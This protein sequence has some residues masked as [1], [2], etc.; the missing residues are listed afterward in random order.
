MRRLGLLACL[1]LLLAACSSLPSPSPASA[2]SPAASN[3]PA[4]PAAQ[5]RTAI[6]AMAG[7][8]DVTFD[9]QETLALQPGY[10]LHKPHV[11]HAHEYVQVLEDSPRRIVLQHILVDERGHVTK[12]WRQDWEYEQTRFW[13]YAGDYSWQRRELPAE[14]VRGQWVQTVWQVDDSPRYAGI[15]RWQHDNGVSR[16]TSDSTWRPL[17][18]REHTERDDYDVLVTVNR[19]TI[20]PTGWSHEQ[21]SYKLDRKH[22]KILAFERGNN[23]YVRNNTFDFKAGRDYW[24]KTAPYWEAVRAVWATEFA[25]HEKLGLIQPSNEEFMSNSHFMAIMKQ[26]NDLAI[27]ARP[28]ADREAAVR[29]TLKPFL[30]EDGVRPATMPAVAKTQP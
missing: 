29:A 5:D 23:R 21:D 24:S 3:S 14:A 16:W 2:Q 1:P 20:T 27:N 28:L 19:Q 26:A 15:G 11:S 25:E 12:H 17:P 9:F 22:Q 13:R 7:N 18:R 4:L 6:L 10:A 30:I 8:Y